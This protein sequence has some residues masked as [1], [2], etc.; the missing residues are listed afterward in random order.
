M[1]QM[2]IYIICASGKPSHLTKNFV[3]FPNTHGN[4]STHVV[5][6]L[7]HACNMID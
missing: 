4:P 3:V 2:F 7:Q 6:E 1:A 5:K